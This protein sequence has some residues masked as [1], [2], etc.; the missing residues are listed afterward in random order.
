MFYSVKFHVVSSVI[1]SKVLTYIA[2][3]DSSIPY[4]E[5][6]VLPPFMG[7][8]NTL[9]EVSQTGSWLKVDPDLSLISDKATTKVLFSFSQVCVSVNTQG[10]IPV[11]GHMSLP[12]PFGGWGGGGQEYPSP[13]FFPWSLVPGPFPEEHTPVPAGR[14]GG[15][16]TP[17][18]GVPKTHTGQGYSLTRTRLGYPSAR[19]GLGSPLPPVRTEPPRQEWGTPS[20]PPRHNSRVSSCYTVG[21]MPLTFTQEYFLV[22]I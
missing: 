2:G 9:V 20:P 10:G 22:S 19:K 1:V 14:G 21:G 7:G 11:S 4:G 5:C 3:Y 16:S 6:L 15:Y 13:R 17:R 12:W 18:W 8:L